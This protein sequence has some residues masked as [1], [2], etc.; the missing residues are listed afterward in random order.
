LKDN[1]DGVD[2][3]AQTL[4]RKAQRCL[5]EEQ[6]RQYTPEFKRQMMALA[7]AGCDP[8]SL[9]K[10]FDLMAWTIA[11]WVIQEIDFIKT[12]TLPSFAIC[13]FCHTGVV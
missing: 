13:I 5:W 12:E 1:G 8:A 7:R 6:T 10:E 2:P 11:L 4:Q 3:A 9:A